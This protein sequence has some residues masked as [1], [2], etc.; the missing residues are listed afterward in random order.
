M[1]RAR[2]VWSEAVQN[3]WRGRLTSWMQVIVIG[4]GLAAVFMAE[5]ASAAAAAQRSAS[6]RADGYHVLAVFG[7]GDGN[8]A[9]ERVSRGQCERLVY[10]S[11]VS[12]AGSLGALIPTSIQQAP[13][14]VMHESGATAGVFAVL[15]TVDPAWRDNAGIRNDSVLDGLLMSPS[16]MEA[17]GLVA[18]AAIAVRND[19]IVELD[20]DTAGRGGD[21]AGFDGAASV[22]EAL[23]SPHAPRVPDVRLISAAPLEVLGLGYRSA[24]LRLVPPIGNAETCLVALEGELLSGYTAP[25]TA[26]LADD[27][28]TYRRVL[29]GAERLQTGDDLYSE[30]PSQHLWI[31][32]AAAA[33]ALRA[34]VLWTRRSELALYRSLGARRSEVTLIA[35]AEFVL[36]MGWSLLV[37]LGIAVLTVAMVDP[38][39][40]VWAPALPSLLAASCAVL[41]A[42]LL[43]AVSVPTARP[44]DAMKDR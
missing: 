21:Q 16:H 11:N 40:Y 1:M 22:G 34:L 32:V 14:A 42:G 31:V 33:L 38:G 15:D 44:I 35:A 7:S 3:V 5:W 26:V 9:V 30:R 18:G 13:N 37:A 28:L 8:G 23:T 41:V 20:D 36:I 12:A 27:L 43:A 39:Q 4:I 25:I 6:L 29:L 2:A 10:A 24:M 17:N 19:M